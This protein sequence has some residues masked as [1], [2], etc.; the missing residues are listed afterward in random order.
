[1]NKD[2]SDKQSI[3]DNSK[4]EMPQNTDDT[5]IKSEVQETEKKVD[6]P[7]TSETQD[8]KDNSTE[9][10]EKKEEIVEMVEIPKKRLLELETVEAR[11]LEEIKLERANSIN[12]RKRM[13]KQRDEFVELAAVRVLT[14][15]LSV[16]EDLDRIVEKGKVEIP[17]TH[18]KGIELLQQRTE[19][20]FTSENVEL[21]KIE[22]N[23]TK[24]DPTFH[25]AI[26]AVPNPD[27]PPNTIMDVTNAGFKKGDRVI[28]A[29]KVVISQAPPTKKEKEK[30]EDEETEFK[31]F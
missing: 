25:E 21:I 18:F 3:T 16:K 13:E 4:Q 23:K 10:E 6:D 15:L 14:K 28:R 30:Q 17:E 11:V 22:L 31:E 1:M 24:Y 2:D 12:F 8:V 7:V 20:I 26:V 5:I 9:T 27:L 19:G 29:A